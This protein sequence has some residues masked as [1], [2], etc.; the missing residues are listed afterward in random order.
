[1][2]GSKEPAYTAVRMDG[3]VGDRDR[4]ESG[5]WGRDWILGRGGVKRA[6][7]SERYISNGEAQ[8]GCDGGWIKRFLTGLP[9]GGIDRARAQH[10]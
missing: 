7:N 4:E 3:M 8:E 1:M 9:V 10:P 5:K 2:G 6:L